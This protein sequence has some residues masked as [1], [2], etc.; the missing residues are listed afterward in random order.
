MVVDVIRA[1]GFWIFTHPEFRP[2]VAARN[3][4]MFAVM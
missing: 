4:E 3:E 2:E 1:Q